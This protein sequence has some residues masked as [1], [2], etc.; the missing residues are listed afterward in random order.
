MKHWI[1]I[2]ICLICLMFAGFATQTKPVGAAGNTYYVATT[3]LDSNDGSLTHP[4]L[5]INHAASVAV[6][7]DM[8]YVRTG[9]YH[10]YVFDCYHSGASGNPITF[11]N[12]PGESPVI[13]GTGLANPSNNYGQLSI[14]T[15]YGGKR[16]I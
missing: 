7:G 10:E 12:Y 3:G 6:A 5:T 8:V 16:Y 4:W 13:D 15:N 2:F 14:F 1:I 9:I 11:E